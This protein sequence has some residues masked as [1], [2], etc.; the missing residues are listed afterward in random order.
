MTAML[1]AGPVP[2][3]ASQRS[4]RTEAAANNC[5][6]KAVT[7]R[8]A[9]AQR[10][11]AFARDAPNSARLSVAVSAR[12]TRSSARTAATRVVASGTASAASNRRFAQAQNRGMMA[13]LPRCAATGIASARFVPSDL[14]PESTRSVP[15]SN[16]VSTFLAKYPK[17]ETAMYFL[18]WCVSLPQPLALGAPPFR[19]GKRFLFVGCRPHPHMRRE[20]HAFADYAIGPSNRYMLNVK[21]NILNKQIYNF[22]PYPW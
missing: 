7:P 22:F 10:S 5:A 19:A 2:V 13:Y 12:A 14:W 15:R 11:A 17:V 18:F 3:G 1:R 4:R 21:F 16:P 8:V 6:A 20:P 9:H